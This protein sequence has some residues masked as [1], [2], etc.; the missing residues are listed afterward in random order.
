MG[1]L[2]VL[3]DGEHHAAMAPTCVFCFGYGRI[4]SLRLHPHAETKKGPLIGPQLAR[5][6]ATRDEVRRIAVNIAKLPDLLNK[7]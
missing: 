3:G 2:V 5:C 4:P 1:S 6:P 7:G